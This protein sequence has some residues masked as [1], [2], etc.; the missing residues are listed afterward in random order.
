MEPLNIAESS[1]T[2]IIN[3]DKGTG[4]FEFIGR[5]LHDNPSSFYKSAISWL[6][7]YAKSPNNETNLSFKFEYLNTE[8][9]KSILDILTVMECIDGVKVSWYF[10]EED[11]DMEEIGEEIAE[12]VQIPFEF[13]PYR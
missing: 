11:E 9:A 10:N 7:D 5:S 2:P 3:L 13:V 12:L 8:S 1:E 6:S 4:L